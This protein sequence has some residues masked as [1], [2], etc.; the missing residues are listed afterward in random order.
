MM[1]IMEN[2]SADA[3]PVVD[4]HGTF[5]KVATA[6]W[7]I[8]FAGT[9]VEVVPARRRVRWGCIARLLRDTGETNYE[10][11]PDG[12]PLRN[13]VSRQILRSCSPTSTGPNCDV[14]EMPWWECAGICCW[15]CFL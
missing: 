3:G 8:A 10:S 14:G 4:G 13:R 1:E 5:P 12:S 9:A 2:A 11:H 6:Q 15:E 7:I